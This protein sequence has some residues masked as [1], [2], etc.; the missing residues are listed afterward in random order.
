MTS[1]VLRAPQCVKPLASDGRSVVCWSAAVRDQ[2]AEGS[3]DMGTLQYDGVLVEFDDRLLAHLQ[4]VIVAKIRR[5]ESFLMSWRD[6]SETGN[7]HSAVWIHPA[8]NLYFKFSGGRQA[9]INQDWLTQLTDS[10]NSARGMLITREPQPGGGDGSV[11]PRIVEASAARR[12]PM[13][14]HVKAEP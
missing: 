4:I 9:S 10:A 12:S 6:S 14:P 1:M 2:R 3:D 11:G 8:Q 13:P 5:G 7:G